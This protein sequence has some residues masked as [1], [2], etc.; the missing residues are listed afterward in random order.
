MLSLLFLGSAPTAA[1]AVDALNGRI[2]AI[3]AEDW[4]LSGLEVALEFG[5][6]LAAEIRI[7]LLVLPAAK[8]SLRD[9]LVTCRRFDITLEEAR[10]R[11][12]IFT[13]VLPGA[14][15][16]TFSGEVSH[17]FTSG[18]TRFT[19][20]D[21]PL[22]EGHVW[23]H[24][25]ASETRLDL[26]FRGEGLQ[27]AALAAMGAE[28]DSGLGAWSAAGTASASGALA[29]ESG[30]VSGVSLHAE[31]GDASVS[32]E[33]GTVVAEALRARLDV[34]ASE[35]AAGYD[36]TSRFFA[37][38]GE[39]YVEP[40]YANVNEHALTFEL[41]GFRHSAGDL[42]FTR[43]NFTQA[44]LIEAAGTLSIRVPQSEDAET[45]VSGSV[46]LQQSSVEAI[47][48]GLLQVFLAGTIA[49]S[50]ETEGTVAGNMTFD[51]NALLHADLFL[52]SVTVN[53]MDQRFSVSGLE[54]EIHW[55]GPAGVVE[56]LKPSRLDWQ[57]ASVYA[58][59]LQ[60]GELV[61]ALGGDDLR[62]LET[63]RIPAMGGA[64]VVNRLV[65]KDYG[66]D[67]ASGLLDATLEPVQ[68]GQLSS[69]FGWPAFSGTLGG[70][71]PMMQYNDGV[72]TVGGSLRANA[73]GGGIEFANLRLEQ[74]F[75]LVPRLSG[76]LRLR[77]LDLEQLTNTFSFGLIQGRLSGDVTGLDMVSW[78]PVAMDLSLYTTV[79]DS[80]RKRI[81]QRAVE[82]LASVGGGGAAAALSSGFM[83]FFQEFSYTRIGL[84]CVLADGVCAM[85]GAGPA[86]EN[87]FGQGYY[88]VKGSGLPRIDV[89]GYRHQ[90]SWTELVRQL[91]SITASGPPVVN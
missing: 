77:R 62:L 65:V 2:A 39:A 17:R 42:E 68:L 55:P 21:L 40:F 12:A 34:T 15:R 41:D 10:C 73:F 46:Q 81:S 79:D 18:T 69:A 6:T 11:D 38:A 5:E 60:A 71:L 28:I 16:E 22:A 61:A 48:S 33:S 47:Y 58:I 51:K 76:D 26:E 57:S 75:G 35:S 49:G 63:L 85:S 59:P 4:A 72:L 31:L 23:L 43:F 70:Q 13:V 52:S 19:L 9:T 82:N 32:N 36:F 20:R 67:D 84:R 64:L 8:L 87:A 24:G 88:I 89:V 91:G 66:K 90:V 37:D 56:D 53:D 86:G 80:S 50:L 44:S 54:G 29:L 7:D 78:R 3:T 14:G 83:K 27:L 1:V 45:L 74:P 25:T 30:A